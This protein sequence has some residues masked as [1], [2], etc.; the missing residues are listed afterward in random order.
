MARSG[1][2]DPYLK[3]RVGQGPQL[4]THHVKKTLN[5]DWHDESLVLPIG[6]LDD[7]VFIEVWDYGQLA[8]DFMG[9]LS[10]IP[11][12]S[13]PWW[14]SPAES[15]LIEASVLLPGTKTGQ[16]SSSSTTPPSS[17]AHLTLPTLALTPSASSSALPSSPPLSPHSP[18]SSQSLS[19]SLSLSA[20]AVHTL[21]GD[22]V[23]PRNRSSVALTSH[24]RLPDAAE[25]LEL[26]PRH[27][28]SRGNLGGGEIMI[29]VCR[30][31]M[32]P[33]TQLH[34]SSMCLIGDLMERLEDATVLLKL[35]DASTGKTVAKQQVTNG[36]YSPESASIVWPEKRENRA[37]FQI[38]PHMFQ[39]RV[40]ANVSAVVD[41]KRTDLGWLSYSLLECAENMTLSLRPMCQKP[42]GSQTR[43]QHM[44]V[45]VRSGV[46]CNFAFQMRC[47]APSYK[48]PEVR[49]FNLDEQ[50][51]VVK[52]ILDADTELFDRM[53]IAGM[54]KA[55][56]VTQR[57]TALALRN[58]LIKAVSKTL[59]PEEKN[60]FLAECRTFF[61]H[62][63]STDG[64]RQVRML[65][66]G[67]RVWQ[68]AAWN[69]RSNLVFKETGVQRS[70]DDPATSVE[71]V[72]GVPLDQ[73]V[74]V[75]GGKL[76]IPQVVEECVGTLLLF[77]KTEGLFRIAGTTSRVDQL[78]AQYDRCNTIDLSAESAHDVASLFIRFF[79]DL[80]DP[81]FPAR[82]YDGVLRA[83]GSLRLEDIRALIDCLPAVHQ[84]VMERFFAFLSVVA[85]HAA[86]NKMTS[87]NL[88]VC[89]TP[90][91]IR[92]EGDDPMK[93]IANSHKLNGLVAFIVDN[94]AALFPPIRTIDNIHSH[95]REQEA[96][97][98]MYVVADRFGELSLL[99]ALDASIL[100]T[101]T[102]GAP[103]AISSDDVFKLR[104]YSH[105]HLLPLRNIYRAGTNFYPI[106]AH[107][108]GLFV[109]ILTSSMGVYRE[110]EVINFVRQLLSAVAYLHSE[111]HCHREI[112][113]S[114]I[115]CSVTSSFPSSSSSSS[116]PSSSSPA[117][118]H[119]SLVIKLAGG[120]YINQILDVG[121]CELDVRFAAPEVLTPATAAIA[122]RFSDMWSV[123]C[124]AYLLLT[125]RYPFDAPTQPELLDLITNPAKPLAFENQDFKSLPPAAC[126]FVRSL[127]V[128]DPLSRPS[129][130]DSLRHPWISQIKKESSLTDLKP[131]QLNLKGTLDLRAILAQR[132]SS[133]STVSDP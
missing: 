24:L 37:T 70:F 22:S 2:S 16:D 48:S 114:N 118:T 130:V 34:M 43:T 26:S 23:S 94:A 117:S 56:C 30:E 88:A 39:H 129:A 8:D 64:S 12:L 78:V 107:N 45:S 76:V 51:K 55:A 100:G 10:P 119:S 19:L 20:G 75:S 44:F 31:P 59:L 46:R 79:M 92:A 33:S 49:S 115:Y 116:S 101:W 29:S 131:A 126:S 111:N 85:G 89:W 71:G 80:P 68:W 105:P 124:V 63:V 25:E 7:S 54:T 95:F 65:R 86:V 69:T 102:P 27:P 109:E 106:Y 47:T 97:G 87:S 38:G 66:S 72:F 21:P 123:G 132:K 5:P 18:A 81:L 4:K 127:L 120:S 15:H 110:T 93:L 112:Q 128:R 28:A 17:L 67:E 133:A 98:D 125:G 121:F 32:V 91:I 41:R 90:V 61:L 11:V 36:A 83:A 99:R 52:I 53:G 1:T 82:L 14:R 108:E 50:K 3:V 40:I 60:D 104:N 42:K 73:T 58:D 96:I 84:L 9:S 74:A 35:V 77:A 113:P 57:T 6:S 103:A 62:E 13:T 122:S